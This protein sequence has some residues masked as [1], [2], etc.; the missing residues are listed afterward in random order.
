[1]RP[2][3]W[4]GS[5]GGVGVVVE[6]WG[7]VSDGE[8]GWVKVGGKITA[9]KESGRTSWGRSDGAGLLQSTREGGEW[10][11]GGGKVAWG[12]L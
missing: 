10:L 9:G 5:M 4:S 3:V 8:G 11:D 1:M 7:C 6:R 12:K 2:G